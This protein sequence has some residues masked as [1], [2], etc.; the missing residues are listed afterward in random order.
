MLLFDSFPCHLICAA[1]FCGSLT[2]PNLFR[3]PFI[4]PLDHQSSWRWLQCG[5]EKPCFS[6]KMTT[7]HRKHAKQGMVFWSWVERLGVK[8]LHL[9]FLG[10]PSPAKFIFNVKLQLNLFYTGEKLDVLSL[11][12]VV[13]MPIRETYFIFFSDS[14][15]KVMVNLDNLII[16]G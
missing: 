5:K 9:N 12:F 2:P 11:F 13:C 1:A 14:K 4:N 16:D 7:S 8:I 3:L 6:I 15:Q 10:N